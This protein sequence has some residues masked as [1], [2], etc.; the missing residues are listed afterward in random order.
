MEAFIYIGSK[1]RKEESLTRHFANGIA[2][3]YESSDTPIDEAA[4]ESGPVY[5]IKPED[6]DLGFEGGK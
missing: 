5:T 2:I 4:F 3:V 1:D 6:S